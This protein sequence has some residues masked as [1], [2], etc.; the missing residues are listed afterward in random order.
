MGNACNRGAD[1]IEFYIQCLPRSRSTWLWNLLQVWGVPCSHDACLKRIP[2]PED[3]PSSIDTWPVD[4][5]FL[6]GVI[7]RDPYQSKKAFE[8]AFNI[9]ISVA[10]FISA[11]ECLLETDSH[12]ISF[13][14]MSK[15]DKLSEFIK[16]VTSEEIPEGFINQMNSM[17]VSP[18][19][20]DISWHPLFSEVV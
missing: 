8:K 6:S 1:T 7:L 4:T 9:S 2:L 10:P 11:Y 14:D 19:S 13:E 15:A 20:H 12:K 3:Y 17:V 16:L 5:P 18:K